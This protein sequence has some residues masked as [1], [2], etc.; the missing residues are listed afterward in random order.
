MVTS[1]KHSYEEPH[2]TNPKI[3]CQVPPVRLRS[4]KYLIV[5]DLNTLADYDPGLDHNVSDD[6]KQPDDAWQDGRDI[7]YFPSLD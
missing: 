6:A 4:L 3:Q 2:Q 7:Q 5:I 1:D